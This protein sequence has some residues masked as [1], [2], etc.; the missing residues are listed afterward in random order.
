MLTTKKSKMSWI[1][2][3]DLDIAVWVACSLIGFIVVL[4]IAL[5]LLKYGVIYGII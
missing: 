3:E 1:S 2:D 5:E 4:A